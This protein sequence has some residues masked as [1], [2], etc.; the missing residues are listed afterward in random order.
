MPEVDPGVLGGIKVRIGDMQYDAT[1]Q[2]RI[3]K[4]RDQFLARGSHEI[5]SG[6]NRLSVGE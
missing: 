2:N 1:V 3:N 5:Q 4:L 6:R